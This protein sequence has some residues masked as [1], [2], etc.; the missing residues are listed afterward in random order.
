MVRE[1]N[2][3]EFRSAIESGKTLVADFWAAWCGPCRMLAPVLDELS[4]SFADKAEF[5][6]V[7]V[8]DNPDLSQ[9]YGIMS[10]PCVMI[11]RGGVVVEKNVGFVPK[12]VM[13]EFI[14]KNV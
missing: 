3:A 13:S 9:E 1:M 10:I 8:D 14:E 2:T 12:Q 7:N 11:F 4:E 6:K 5:V